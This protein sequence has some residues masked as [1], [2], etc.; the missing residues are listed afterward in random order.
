MHTSQ[1]AKATLFLCGWFAEKIDIQLSGFS[2]SSFFF[3]KHQEGFYLEDIYTFAVE[4][5][6]HA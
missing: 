5:K 4:F 2:V 3:P 6:R 1:F